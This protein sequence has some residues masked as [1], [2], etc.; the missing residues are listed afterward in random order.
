MGLKLLLRKEYF[1][2]FYNNDIYYGSS[3]YT[4]DLYILNL[5]MLKFNINSKNNILENQYPYYIWYCRLNHNNK[6]RI[7]IRIIY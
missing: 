1:F 7:T 5:E 6:I 2:S 3:T 4:N